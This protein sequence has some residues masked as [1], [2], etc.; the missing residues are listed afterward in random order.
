MTSDSEPLPGEDEMEMS[1]GSFTN[2]IY[3]DVNNL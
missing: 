1:D 2:I 3:A